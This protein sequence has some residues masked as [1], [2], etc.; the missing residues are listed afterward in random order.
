MDDGGRPV[1]V[2][3]TAK[4]VPPASTAARELRRTDDDSAPFNSE[5]FEAGYL[6]RL[7]GVLEC[8]AWMAS[9]LGRRRRGLLSFGR[10]ESILILCIRNRG[11]TSSN[12]L[13]PL[14]HLR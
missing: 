8:Y 5:Q 11:A 14:W 12:G 10:A 3:Y 6:T 13:L 4:D 1:A 7:S 2:A 9:R